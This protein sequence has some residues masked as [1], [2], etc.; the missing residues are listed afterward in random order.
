M[1]TMTATNVFLSRLFQHANED[2]A[3]F[4]GGEEKDLY[5]YISELKTNLTLFYGVLK[6]KHLDPTVW[7]WI[8]TS[9]WKTITLD[10][11]IK[12]PIIKRGKRKGT[13]ITVFWFGQDKKL[14]TFD[15]LGHYQ[16]KELEDLITT[17]V[18]IYHTVVTHQ[19]AVKKEHF[20]EDFVPIG[21]SSPKRPQ[22][23]DEEEQSDWRPRSIF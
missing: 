10:T 16:S 6:S 11:I 8:E 7:K 23:R 20:V 4:H 1:I 18:K 22:D 19:H 5:P 3:G 15:V 13:E 14:E 12:I 17:M 2:P 21:A 9:Y